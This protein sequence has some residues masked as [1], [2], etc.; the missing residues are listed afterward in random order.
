MQ[1]KELEAIRLKKIEQENER[2]HEETKR[3]AKKVYLK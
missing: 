3:Q 2:L 1:E